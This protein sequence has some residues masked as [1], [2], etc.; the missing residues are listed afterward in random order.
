MLQPASVLANFATDRFVPPLSYLH[1]PLSDLGVEE[2]PQGEFG[3]S[4]QQ[5]VRYSGLRLVKLGPMSFT[6]QAP[7]S[8]R[9][10][11][12]LTGGHQCFTW[13]ETSQ[14]E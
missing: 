5:T 8:R 1:L 2:A 12:F 11:E 7:R 13:N 3:T 10:E 14:C 9:V 6:S 4:L